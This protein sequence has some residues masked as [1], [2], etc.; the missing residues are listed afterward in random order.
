M[1]LV[2]SGEGGLWVKEYASGI[3]LT[4]SQSSG[5]LPYSQWM[6]Q[7]CFFFP[8]SERTHMVFNAKI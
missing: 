8:A 1:G 2:G 5:F 7:G 6:P 4:D 3:V